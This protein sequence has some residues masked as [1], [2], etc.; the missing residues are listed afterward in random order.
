MEHKEI[1]ER[2]GRTSE[3]AQRFGVSSQVVSMWKRQG[4]P[5]KYRPAIKDMADF[6]LPKDFLSPQP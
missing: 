4:I 5:W 2:L 1:I 6:N 3:I